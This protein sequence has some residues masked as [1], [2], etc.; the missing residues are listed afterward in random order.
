M[1]LGIGAKQCVP[2]LAQR[3]LNLIQRVADL[4][5]QKTCCGLFWFLLSWHI[6]CVCVFVFQVCLILHPVNFWTQQGLSI[7]I[8]VS[9]YPVHIYHK[10][11]I[12]SRGPFFG[13]FFSCEQVK[14]LGFLVTSSYRTCFGP[15]EG[16]H[17]LAAEATGELL[18]ALTNLQQIAAA[19]HKGIDL[20]KDATFLD[21]KDVGSQVRICEFLC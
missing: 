5:L 13:G 16:W 11:V 10:Q 6:N 8:Y 14:R 2:E 3:L 17:R 4:T 19:L 18:K 12:Q 7:Y 15:A 21:A 9:Q 20:E 1:F